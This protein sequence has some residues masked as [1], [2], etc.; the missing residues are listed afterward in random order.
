MSH[1]LT[2]EIHSSMII[3][4]YIA[5]LSCISSGVFSTT[6]LKHL[7]ALCVVTILRESHSFIL[8]FLSLNPTNILHPID[9]CFRDR[10]GT[11]KEIFKSFS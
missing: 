6:I 11:L 5:L 3:Y 10:R 8:L 7:N 9:R 2:V 1:N 4:Y